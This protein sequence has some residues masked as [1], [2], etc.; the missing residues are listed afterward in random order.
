MELLNNIGDWTPVSVAVGVVIALLRYLQ[1]QARRSAMNGSVAKKR[2]DAEM[3]TE[4]RLMARIG[5][6][7]KLVRE[8]YERNNAL[9]A[10]NARLQ[11]QLERYNIPK[12]GSEH[13]DE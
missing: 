12:P 13:H 1:V 10:R 6:L 5:E 3:E 7:E 4:A 2:I 9:A 11:T 8:L